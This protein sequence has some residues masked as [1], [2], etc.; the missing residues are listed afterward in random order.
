MVAR[1][2]LAALSGGLIALSYP[3]W[4]IASASFVALVPLL[5]ALQGTRPQR[6]F[7]LG[8]V[9]GC[10]MHLLALSW[11]FPAIG[12]FQELSAAGS[13]G[14]F[15]L[16]VGYQALPFALFAVV[17]AWLESAPEGGDS[18]IRPPRLISALIVA[19]AWVIAE[20]L[21][22]RIIPWN[23][24]DALAPATWLRQAADLVGVYGMS[25]VIVLVN[26]LL[27]QAC[28]PT[29]VQYAVRARAFGAAAAV[30]ALL[31]GYGIVRLSE[32]APASA[33]PAAN[34]I[35]RVTIVQGNLPSGRKDLIS[36]NEAAWQTYSELSVTGSGA[37]LL[38]WPE[39]V[40]RVYLRG[41]AAYRARLHDLALH[42]DTSLFV[43]ALDVPL[44]PPGELNSGYLIQPREAAK[45]VRV[46][47]GPDHHNDLQTY[48]KHWLLPFGEYV[49]GE[50]LLPVMNG[51]RTTG[52]FR[53]GGVGQLL[54]LTRHSDR[55]GAAPVVERG[56]GGSVGFAPSICFEAILPGVFNHTVRDGAGFLVNI[57]DDGWF[58][59]TA[60]P[61]QHLAAARLRAVET[62]R[63]LVR[64][65][66]SG[67]SAY[68]D[69]TGEIVA[70]L[71]FGQT[72]VLSH[73][74]E[75]SHR[76]PPY[77]RFG[78]WPVWAAFVIVL[79]AAARK[80]AVAN[81]NRVAPVLMLEP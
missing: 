3:R 13:L 44:Q 16:F 76:L 2:L 58:G 75:L 12:R 24:G 18:R 11:I 73:G 27:A 81:T 39:T 30:L 1:L 77:V 6:A 67:I 21:L 62:R 32:L 54:T 56:A 41:D 5:L 65:S 49:P 33:M 47:A 38:V 72:G 69:P 50:F 42:L 26:A 80:F 29:N 57:T 70:S 74:V 20:W 14:Y 48:H 19:S 36:A 59:D 45:F 10:A 51:W 63:W 8:W 17:I 46:V 52:E 23:L 78:N 40:L 4:A 64:A 31:V 25:F 34:D 60:G 53:H 43:G 15:L 55:T 7:L 9:A 71:G 61:Y 66:N 28:T 68:V 79:A 22:P 37:D 35:V